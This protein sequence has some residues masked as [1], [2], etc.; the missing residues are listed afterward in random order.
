MNLAHAPARLLVAAVPLMTAIVVPVAHAVPAAANSSCLA[1]APPGA[2][3]TATVCLTSPADS[4]TLNGDAQVTATISFTGTSPGVQRMIFSL[5]GQY[6]LTDYATPYQF[7]LSSAKYVDGAHALTVQAMLRDTFVTQ[8]AG[9]DLNFNNGITTPPV[10]TNTFT[11][12]P[13]TTPAPGRPFLLAA[14]GDGAGGE[15]A[16][17]NTTDQIASWNPNLFLYLG[18]VYEKGSPAE[19]QNWYGATNSYGRFRAITDPAIGNHEYTAGQ[20]PGYF[21]YWDNAPHYYSFNTPNGWHIIS[22]DSNGPSAF[23]QTAVGSPQYNWLQADLQANAPKCTIAYW[24]HPLYNIGQEGPTTR[25]QDI[26]TLLQNNGVHLVLNGHDH[27][28]QRWAPMDAFG[29]VTQGGITELVAG[30]GGHA[31]GDFVTSDPNVLASATAFGA[32]RLELNVSG[33]QWQFISQ[34]GTVLDS[35]ASACSPKVDATPPTA[36]TN[37]AA[38]AVSPTEVDLSWTAS[39]DNVGVAGYRVYRD[40]A[41]VG[42][43]TSTA[44]ADT[45]VQPATNYSYS[46]IADDAA[47]NTSA[48]SNTATATTPASTLTESLGGLLTASAAA[49]SWSSNRTDVFVRGTDNALYH[50]S[51]NGSTW[52]AW[53]RLGGV[54]T[55]APGAVSWGPDR[56]DVFVRGTDNAL[57][58]KGW[59]GG[60]S[61]WESLGGVLTSAPDVASWGPNRLDVFVR[62]TDNALWHKGWDG[63]WSNWESLGG[64]LT[65]DP[66]TVSWGPNR[67]DAFVRGTD[68]ALW[69]KWWDGVHWI[70]WESP[71]GT[72]NSGPAASSCGNA[73][74][75]VFW[76]GADNGLLRK[77]YN[78]SG[79]GVQQS[80]GG[81]WTSDPAAVCRAGTSTVDLFLRGTDNALWHTTANAS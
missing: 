79:W 28:Y 11:P 69:H 56:I 16:E 43:P 52:S 75:N 15:P 58:H 12:S 2:S 4:A 71:G 1:S 50:R 38:R 41:L 34:D 30:T 39:T 29:N 59:D 3:Y 68:N 48:A 64:I 31:I 19:F 45:G 54:L 73:G 51:W 32:L 81:Q 20:A 47:G 61:N 76:L 6:L 62:G 24:H 37:L 63:R 13:G 8:P 80:L 33:S 53:E 9:V 42:S 21:D 22:L 65:S 25:M 26:W 44:Y 40:G 7:T 36:P 66:S 23:G 18:D 60:W 46:T 5:D 72:L 70:G 49:T 55:S 35:G 78:A 10:N 17:V 27:T 74:L 14:A 67:I 57:W 77:A